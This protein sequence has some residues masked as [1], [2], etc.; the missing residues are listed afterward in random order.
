VSGVRVFAG[1]PGSFLPEYIRNI[2]VPPFTNDTT[3]FDVDR[4]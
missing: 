1:R 4:G 2:G 3:V